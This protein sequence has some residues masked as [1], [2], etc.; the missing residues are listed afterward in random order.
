M[1]PGS[2]N[3][4]A[5]ELLH[6][7]G[8]PPRKHARVSGVVVFCILSLCLASSRVATHTQLAAPVVIA[9]ANA[10]AAVH[11]STCLL[12]FVCRPGELVVS[13]GTSATLFGV[14]GQPIIDPTCAVCPFCDATG[15]LLPLLLHSTHH[16]TNA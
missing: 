16:A 15:K 3:G 4:A 13:L 1:C 14:S 12:S 11:L 6:L 2:G 7:P 9:A 5:Q 8:L 10:A